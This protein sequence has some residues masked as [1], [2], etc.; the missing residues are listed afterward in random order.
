[1]KKI[2]ER[3]GGEAVTHDAPNDQGGGEGG[4]EAATK[5]TKTEETAAGDGNGEGGEGK[6]EKTVEKKTDDEKASLLKDMMKYKNLAREMQEKV[7]KYEGI[8]PEKARAALAAAEAAQV[9][10][11]E[12]KGQYEE[13]IKQVREQNEAK[14]AEAA[15]RV[16]ALEAKLNEMA[17]AAVRA[18]IR[19]T[20]ANSTFIRENLMISGEKVQALY[21]EYF[22][23]V[24]GQMVG[25]NKP[26]G[27]EGRS[28]LVDASGAPLAFEAAVEKVL[29]ADPE[30]ES[31]A[32]S[33]IKGAAGS[34]PQ[35]IAADTIE[36]P[37]SSTDRIRAGLSK[38]GGG[39]QIDLSK[40]RR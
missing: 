12:R 3:L 30:W 8:D 39:K 7:K 20:F 17:E 9:A 10:E 23:H 22:D 38:L 5:E 13:I 33:K 24:D 27:A 29:K 16:Q 14:V 4:G 6:D 19:S 35:G 37:Q 36:K 21:G 26:R 1:M 25:Y 32:K 2:W 18:D 40:V 11:L 34:H 15:A 31:L 28:P